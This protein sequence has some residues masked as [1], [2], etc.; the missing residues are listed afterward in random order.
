MEGSTWVKGGNGEESAAGTRE[1]RE[2]RK[3][4][5]V[6]LTPTHIL[7]ALLLVQIVQPLRLPP[8]SLPPPPPPIACLFTLPPPPRQRSIKLALDPPHLNPIGN[9][10]APCEPVPLLT[11]TKPQAVAVVEVFDGG[12]VPLV[13]VVGPVVLDGSVAERGEERGELDVFEV[14]RG[15]EGG[16]IVGLDGEDAREG[17]EHCSNDGGKGEPAH[18][19]GLGGLR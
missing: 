17:E 18:E 7:R 13:P 4:A 2:E 9:Q 15:A 8:R 3:G 19:V 10:P 1:T 12:E 11:V 6:G 16:D 5:K 14:V